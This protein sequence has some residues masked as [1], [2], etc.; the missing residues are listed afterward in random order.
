[1]KISVTVSELFKQSHS[2]GLD[3]DEWLTLDEAGQLKQRL[4][5]IADRA[6]ALGQ[7]IYTADFK[8]PANVIR[9]A[10]F[11]NQMAS[12]ALV[13]LDNGDMF[14]AARLAL[15]TGLQL[16]RINKLL[17][18][19]DRLQIVITQRKGSQK[20]GQAKKRSEWATD[21]AQHLAG[22]GVS[23]PKAWAWIPEDENL[24]FALNEDVAVYRSEEG[25][26]VVAIDEVTGGEIGSQSRSNFLKRYFSPAK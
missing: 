8:M 3:L 4:S 5:Y 7:T 18:V 26:R 20:G 16:E 10:R 23:F 15:D 19:F 6:G 11:L 24:P 14:T 2:G 22:L 9:D 12:G 1:V 17:F 21:L 25:Q 13:G